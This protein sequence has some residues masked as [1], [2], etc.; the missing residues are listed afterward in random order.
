[1]IRRR[2]VLLAAA[3]VIF[4]MVIAGLWAL[5]ELVRRVAV[6][7]AGQGHRAPGHHRGRRPQPLHRLGGGEGVPSGR[8]GG[9]RAFRAVRAPGGEGLPACAGAPR[10]P[11][12]PRGPHRPHRAGDPHGRERVQLLRHP[13]PPAEE[14]G[15][16]DE[17]EPIHRHA[18]PD[19]ARSLPA[20]HRGPRGHAAGGLVAPEPRRRGLVGDHARRPP[21]PGHA[22]PSLRR[23]EHRA[24]QS[25]VP[26]LTAR[27]RGD[28]EAGR[29][30]PHPRGA[31]HSESGPLARERRAGRHPRGLLQ[32]DGR[33]GGG[34]TGG[35]RDRAGPLRGEPQRDARTID[36][37]R[38]ARRG[39]REGRR[40]RPHRGDL[41]RRDRGADLGMVRRSSGQIDLLRPSAA[42]SSGAPPRS[43]SA[44][45][46]VARRRRLARAHCARRGAGA[47]VAG[48]GGADHHGREPDPAAR[49][50]CLAARPVAPGGARRQAHRALQHG[51]RG[52]GH[53]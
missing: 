25:G 3:I 32:A 43:G 21:R 41:Q 35:G 24:R 28:R 48:E 2:P 49:R 5:P 6:D 18:R 36:R 46:E 19:R 47:G 10:R 26:A 39:D 16:G 51:R 22:A 13:R 11:P 50:R 40:P 53:R 8:A 14:R 15:Q 9:P 44:P 27:G 34:A 7:Q 52:A 29:L 23:G 17:G 1:M 42:S 12:P 4:L 38:A 20:A 33:Q 45:L 30:R 31:V 37:N